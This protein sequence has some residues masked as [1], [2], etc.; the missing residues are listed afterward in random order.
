MFDF[1]TPPRSPPFA[2]QMSW[3]PSTRYDG[4][5]GR[6]RKLI[7]VSVVALVLF[8]FFFH[9]SP[10]RV[11]AISGL[12]PLNEVDANTNYPPSYERL[13]SW[14]MSLPQHDL[15]LPYPEG[16]DGRFVKFSSQ[17]QQLGWNN[18]LNELLMNSYLAY[19]SKRAYVFQ[20]YVWKKEYYPWSKVKY[21]TWPPRTPLNALISGPTAGGPWGADDNAPRSV[22]EEYFDIVCPKQ[23]RR[24]INTRDIK[25]GIRWES[26]QTIFSTWQ[27]LL[28]EAPERCIEIQ[29][30]KRSEDNFPQIFDLFL[31]GSDRIL[32][33]WEEFRDSPVSQLLQTSPIV[34]A[35]IARNEYLF[36]PRDNVG[37]VGPRN[38]YD[39]MLAIH[40]RRGDFKEACLSLAT[41]NSTF[42]SWNLLPSLPDKFVPPQGGTW[43]NNTPENVA[44]YMERC[45]A[46]FAAVAKKIHDSRDDFLNLKEDGEQKVLDTLY[47]LT[48]DDSE[49]LRQLKEALRGEGWKLIIT[50]K[51]LVLDAEGV[52]TGMAVDMDI[53]RRAAVF[54]GNGYNEFTYD[55]MSL[56]LSVTARGCANSLDTPTCGGLPSSPSALAAALTLAS[57]NLSHLSSMDADRKSTVSSFYGGRKGSMDALNQDFPSTQAPTA[58]RTGRDDA[59]SFFNP[60]PSRPSM[61]RLGGRQPS[62]GYNSSTFYPG[63]EEPLKGGRDEEEEV[64]DVYADFN[65]AGPRYSSAF[66]P[67]TV[68]SQ[69]YQPLEPQTPSSKVEVEGPTNQTPVEMVTVPALGPEWAKSELRDMTKAG[70]R[71]RKSDSRREKWKQWNRGERGMCGS[72][73]TRKV[74]VW[75]MFGLCIAIALVLGFCIPRVPA[76]SF[77]SNNPLVNATGGWSQAIPYTFSRAPAN[78]SFP[79]YASLQLDTSNNFIPITFK[80]MRASVYDLTTGRQVG[81]G[82]LL[83]SQTVPPKAFPQLLLPLNFTY[84]VT[85]D[86]DQTWSNWY[87]ACKNKINYSSGSRPPVQFQLV[88]DLDILVR[89]WDAAD[90]RVRAYAGKTPLAGAATTLPSGDIQPGSLM[91]YH[92]LY[93]LR[94][95]PSNYEEL[96]SLRRRASSRAE[97]SARVGVRNNEDQ[98][99]F[100]DANRVRNT[101]SDH[102]HDFR[103]LDSGFDRIPDG[104]DTI[105]LTPAMQ[106]PGRSHYGPASSDV[107]TSELPAPMGLTGTQRYLGVQEVLWRPGSSRTESDDSV[108]SAKSGYSAATAVS[109]SG[110]T[111]VKR[112]LNLG[113]LH[114][115]TTKWPKPLPLKSRGSFNDLDMTDMEIT[116]S[117]DAVLLESGIGGGTGILGLEWFSRWTSFKWCLLFSVLSVFIYGMAGLCCAIGVWFRI[118][119]N[120]DV[121]FVADDDVLILITLASS[122]LVFTVL[123]GLTG[124]LLSSRPI[125]A[126]YALL[127]WPCFISMCAIGYTAY[128]RATFALDQKLDMSWSQYYTPYG[129]LL[130]QNALKCCGWS[131]PNHG[132]TPSRTCYPRTP[133][134][135]CK[136][137][138][139]RFEQA[140]LQL[141]WSTVFSLVPMHIVNI[142]VVMLCANHVTRTFGTGITP[143][144]YRLTAKDVQED[145]GQIFSLMKKRGSSPME[146]SEKVRKPAI[147]RAL[148]SRVFREDR[149]ETLGLLDKQR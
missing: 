115:F 54:I 86:T 66:M 145:A 105:P 64:W 74:F 68:S 75:F 67:S 77:N 139:T 136:G 33:L 11:R 149:E 142:V 70:K 100:A 124:T 18:C 8:L 110:A 69:G 111:V 48:N 13:R 78:F 47:I 93:G 140:S 36:V 99:P 65:N 85:N 25:P 40:I 90:W 7:I 12:I 79:A 109:S 141:V 101:P 52:D 128:K 49:W 97:L 125:L 5:P 63:R 87:N 32:D 129:R 113:V 119:P 23:E 2:S 26:G 6:R 16:R 114:K 20:D 107:G 37:V 122:I 138:L 94:R 34:N 39:H 27:K 41:W 44:V 120:A 116:K 30:A 89:Q 147:V 42:Y 58:G 53:A 92:S 137:P 118:W 102:H 14:E 71:E 45:L 73:C 15:S 43:G 108:Y 46:D 146:V 62:G 35:A 55:V 96:H 82:D 123:V 59:S 112:G 60:E 76:F 1:C 91:S 72:Y 81:K 50:S 9:P 131:N 10:W 61:D 126:V 104:L 21:R 117:V 51:D 127:L 83:H 22:S 4:N 143:K 19:K 31:W 130:V 57:V 24:I 98:N 56:T 135:G 95:T 132:G 134:P 84:I 88:I 17:V 38:P 133:L 148:S 106:T 80:H 144:R 121:M 3:K 103:H 29:P 28:F